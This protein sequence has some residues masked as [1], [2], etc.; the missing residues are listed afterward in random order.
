MSDL[1]HGILRAVLAV[2]MLLAAVLGGPVVAVVILFF[3]SRVSSEKKDVENGPAERNH[4]EKSK[5]VDLQIIADVPPEKPPMDRKIGVFRCHCT[6]PLL[7]RLIPSAHAG[8]EFRVGYNGASS[9]IV[10]FCVQ[11]CPV[12]VQ[13]VGMN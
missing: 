6:W 10:W 2:I 1:I 7:P 4:A 9:G 11:A 5:T 12:L 3:Y 8:N 13:R